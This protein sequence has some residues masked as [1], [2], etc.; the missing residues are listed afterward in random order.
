MPETKTPQQ[1]R[2]DEAARIKQSEEAGVK[3][4]AYNPAFMPGFRPDVQITEADT[5]QQDVGDQKITAAVRA[6]ADAIVSHPDQHMAPTAGVAG[7]VQAGVGAGT[8]STGG[9]GGEG[10]TGSTGA[11][12]TGTTAAGAPIETGQGSTRTSR[13]GDS[14]STS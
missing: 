11:A 9:A 3:H 6:G 10:T 14:G 13:A 5:H 8:G 12:T 2:D 1:L 4:G 7:G